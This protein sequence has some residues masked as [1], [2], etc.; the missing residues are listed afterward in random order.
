MPSAQAI[1]RKLCWRL[2]EEARETSKR[3]DTTDGLNPRPYIRIEAED[4]ESVAFETLCEVVA[5]SPGMPDAYYTEV[6]RVFPTTR[7]PLDA[8]FPMPPGVIWVRTEALRRRLV[9]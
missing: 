1:V 2:R 9:V 3:L 6:T 7:H 8:V 4:A 5:Q